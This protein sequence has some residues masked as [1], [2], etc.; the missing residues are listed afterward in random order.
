ME[1][2]ELF[3]VVRPMAPECHEGQQEMWEIDN[4]DGELVNT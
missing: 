1:S 3:D 2:K 4:G